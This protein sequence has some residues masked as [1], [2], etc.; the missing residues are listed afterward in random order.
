M[1]NIVLPVWFSTAFVF[2]FTLSPYLGVPMGTILTMFALSPLVLIWLVIYVLK[3][4]VEPQEKFSDGY[5]Y[6]DIKYPIG[7]KSEE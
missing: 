6:C 7:S 2:F 1:K 3:Y 5:W 4:G